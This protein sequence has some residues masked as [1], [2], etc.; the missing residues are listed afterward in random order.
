W[1]ALAT[2]SAALLLPE[3][4]RPLPW[5]VAVANG[6]GFI[7]YLIWLA[8]VTER[9]LRRARPDEAHGR[10]APWR[11][12]WNGLAG[13]ALDVVANSR[14]LRA[15]GEWAPPVSFV[16]DIT[17]VIYCNYLVEADRLAPLVPAGTELQRLGPGGR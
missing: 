6:L 17:D 5:L 9:V 11:H 12:P 13:R 2:G 10:L 8:A 3:S 14:F 7:L 16:S 4:V 15:F 1:G